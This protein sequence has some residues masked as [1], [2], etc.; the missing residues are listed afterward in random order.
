MIERLIWDIILDI[1]CRY[2]QWFDDRSQH[3]EDYR[4]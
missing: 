2:Y 4:R 1:L 3:E